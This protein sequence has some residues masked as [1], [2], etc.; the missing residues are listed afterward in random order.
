MKNL[1]FV[2]VIIAASSCKPTPP[3]PRPVEIDAHYLD[4]RLTLLSD[5]MVN[6][7]QDLPIDSLHIPRSIDPDGQLIAKNSR[8]WTSGFFP[9]TLWQLAAHSKNQKI[10]S[11][12]RAWSAFIEKEKWDDHTHDLGFKVNSTFGKWNNVE[13][14]EENNAII[15]QAAKTL[16]QRY[17][18]TVGAIKSWDWGKDR[19]Q[20]PVI[21]DNMMNLEMLFDATNISG[22][23]IF[24]DIAKQHAETTLAN[25]FRPD[26]SSYHVID[27]DT[28]TGAVINKLTHQGFSHESA[29]SR[30]Q[31]WGMYGF[32]MAYDRTGDKRFLDLAIEIANFVFTHPNLPEDMIPYWDYNAPNIPNEPKDVSAAVVAANAL[33]KISKHDVAN[34][35]KY[36]EWTDKILASLEKAEYQTDKAPFL[37]GRSTGSVPDNFE[38]DEPLS[39]GDYYYVEALLQRRSMLQ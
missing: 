37:L 34:K 35:D 13:H 22:D 20:Y 33:M 4:A 10:L 31:A 16:M 5:K 11:D 36:L 25:H 14:K 12:A 38:V 18:P 32:A 9:G 26:H 28:L 15:V 2:L 29:W 21:I 30:G 24:Y 1:I 39:Y 7:L 19:W 23:S 17:N 8:Q 27:Y 6:Y 3:T